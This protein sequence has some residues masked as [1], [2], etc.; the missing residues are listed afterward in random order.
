VS[1]TYSTNWM[2]PISIDW[3]RERGLTKQVQKKV[4]SKHVANMRGMDIGES[5]MVEEITTNYC[6]GR[7]DIRDDTKEGYDGWSEY[8]LPVMHG[9]DWNALTKFLDG[10][11]T[12]EVVSYYRLIEIFSQQTRTNIRWAPE[13]LTQK[14]C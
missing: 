10:F 12:E 7:I 4:E 6:G 3:F 8:S 13:E 1:V 14:S 2:G 5:Y 9:E 11:E